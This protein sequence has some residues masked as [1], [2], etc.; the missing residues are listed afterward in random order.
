MD[1]QEELKHK[2]VYRTKDVT[3]L[4]GTIGT[5]RFTVYQDPTVVRVTFLPYDEQEETTCFAQYFQS[6]IEVENPKDLLSYVEV[7][8]EL[9]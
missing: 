5:H 7:F 2:V 3:V 1:E 9:L 8:G 6:P 4:D